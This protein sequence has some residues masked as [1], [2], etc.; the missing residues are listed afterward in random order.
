M[1]SFKDLKEDY[2]VNKPKTSEEILKFQRLLFKCAKY[3]GLLDLKNIYDH[4]N[5]GDDKTST[6]M[7]FEFFK[8]YISR[9][10][11]LENHKPI[12]AFEE[13]WT[14]ST[15]VSLINGIPETYK[16]VI[17]ETKVFVSLLINNTLEEVLLLLEIT[18]NR[19]NKGI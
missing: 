18:N 6:T 16:L 14:Y 7:D 11:T 15:G 1:K 10:S 17:T 4:L 9:L 19:L 12:G 8:M 3:H 5:N 13:Y 2:F